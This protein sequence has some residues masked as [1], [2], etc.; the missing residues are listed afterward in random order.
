MKRITESQRNEAV[1]LIKLIQKLS[2]P[3]QMGVLMMIQG[4]SMIKGTTLS[5]PHS[6]PPAPTF[7]ETP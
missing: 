3:E 4:A 6:E 1:N 2:K 5:C 7:E